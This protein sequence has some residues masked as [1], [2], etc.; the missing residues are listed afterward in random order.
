M[1]P[2][3]LCKQLLCKFGSINVGSYLCRGNVS[4]PPVYSSCRIHFTSNSCVLW[5]TQVLSDI[6]LVPLWGG[7]SEIVLI[8]CREVILSFRPKGSIYPEVFMWKEIAQYSWKLV[9]IQAVKKISAFYGIRI[10]VTGSQEPATCLYIESNESR[11]SSAIL[12]KIHFI[13]TFNLPGLLI[14]CKISF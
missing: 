3:L 2:V 14:N 6:L 11:L 1:T 10:F 5:C 12:F 13:L 8:K 4:E 9:V 7:N